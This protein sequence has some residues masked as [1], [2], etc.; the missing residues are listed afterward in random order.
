GEYERRTIDETLD[1]AWSVLSVLPEEELK[2]I[3][4]EIA[5]KYHPKYRQNSSS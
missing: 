2:L 3:R 4:P 1:K 5:R